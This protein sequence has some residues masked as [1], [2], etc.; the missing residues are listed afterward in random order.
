MSRNKSIVPSGICDRAWLCCNENNIKHNPSLFL[1]SK[2]VVSGK[3]ECI[4]DEVLLF[5]NQKEASI[6]IYQKSIGLNRNNENGK[7]VGR[8]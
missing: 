1:S 5:N 8:F 7:K 4:Y 3:Q 6:K 2:N